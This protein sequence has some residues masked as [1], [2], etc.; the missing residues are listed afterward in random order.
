VTPDA[1]LANSVF[2]FWLKASWKLDPEPLRVPDA[3]DPLDAAVVVLL[4]LL[5]AAPMVV[6]TASTMS[7]DATRR[8]MTDKEVPSLGGE[9]G[10]RGR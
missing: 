8:L 4:S 2:A 1:T 3:C 10:H 7:N 5:H 6:K 9:L